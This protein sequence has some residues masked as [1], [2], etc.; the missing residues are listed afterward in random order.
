M[1]RLKVKEVAKSKGV[2]QTRL[3]HL[4]F[5]EASKMRNIYRY[6]DS[7]HNNMTLQVLERIA[8]AL[9]VDVSELIENVPDD[10]D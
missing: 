5:I 2:T 6:P 7:D 3:A 4:S 8:R 1:I 9:G 10:P